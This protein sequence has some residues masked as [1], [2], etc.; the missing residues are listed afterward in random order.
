MS[1]RSFGASQYGKSTGK[2][3]SRWMQ[4]QMV[5]Y[6]G[7][8]GDAVEIFVDNVNGSDNNDGFSWEGAKATIQAGINLARYLPGTTTL[9]D[10][11]DHHSIVFVAPGHY[12]EGEILFSGYNISVI[13]CCPYP[14]K[15]Y[16]VSINYDGA[17]DATAAFAFS[18]SGI[19]LANLHIY[20]DAAL[21]A[22][23][24]A[25]G[26]NNYIHDCVIECDGTNCTYGIQA[27]SLKG[28]W[29]ER[30]IITGSTTAGIFAD[31]G[32]DRYCINGGIRDCQIYSGVA[33]TKGIFIESTMTV[34]NFAVDRNIIQLA[35][36]ATCKGIDDD[37]AGALLIDNYVSVPASA[38]PIESA[39]GDQFVMGNHTAAGT[40]NAD[41]YPTAA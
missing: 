24:I 35:S 13:G 27:Y 14:G 8:K 19:E 21:P 32:A 30:V 18:G 17:A 1:A 9:D 3:Y 2:L 10:T 22:L 26:D 23:F 39:G 33:N 28:S 15:D 7:Y 12:N 16:G 40:V 31:G 25:G 41:P 20:C 29:I 4:G 37:S 11:K 6:P 38:T 36:G 5:V 34:Y